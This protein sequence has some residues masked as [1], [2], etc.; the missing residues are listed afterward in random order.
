[1]AGIARVGRPAKDGATRKAEYDQRRRTLVRKV[2][3]HPELR[4]RLEA[5]PEEWLRYYC[6][7]LFNLP[8]ADS[9][10]QII[11]AVV[12][13]SDNAMNVVV[14]A[15]RGEGKTSILR[16]M[17]VFLI[18]TGRARFPVLGGWTG[19]AAKIGW[20]QWK[21]M[22]TSPRFVEDYPEFA[23]P[24]AESTNSTR[25]NSLVWDDTGKE[26]G[27]D[28]LAVELVIVLPDGRGALAAGSLNGDIKGTNIPLKSGEVIRPDMILLDDPQD[29]DRAG[30]PVFVD[31]VVDKIN[32]Q[33]MCLGGPDSGI[34]MMAAVTIKEPGDVG[35]TL[36]SDP[37]N[38]FIRISRILKWP[39]GFTDKN[40]ACR[41]LWDRWYD[42]F[43]DASTREESFR[44]YEANKAVMIKGMQVAWE[45]RRDRKRK[46]PDAFFSAIA[47]FYKVGE[48]AF[49]S[50]YQNRP[51]KGET[52]VY[53]LTPQII[54]SRTVSLKVNQQP[55][56]SVLRVLC[57]D[58]NPSYAL[59]STMKAFDT[60][61]RGHVMW[62]SL[63]SEDPLPIRNT[64]S[65][66]MRCALVSQALFK[67][68][69]VICALPNPPEHWGIDASGEYFDVVVDFVKNFKGCHA[70]AMCG[71]AGKNYNPNVKSR[72]GI[73]RNGVYECMER[74]KGKWLCFD[75]DIYKETAQ[76]AF[77]SEPGA[78]GSCTLFDGNHRELAIQT[79][80]ETLA[81]KAE[82]AG[83]MHYEWVTQPGKH[84]FL[85]TLSM[86]D[87][88]AG[89]NGIGAFGESAKQGRGRKKISSM[90]MKARYAHG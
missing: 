69:A 32:T 58:L 5:N 79:C 47:D 46:D 88:L 67:L 56:A 29:V 30:D 68:G 9:H 2:C 35:D 19:K 12:D 60:K 43:S 61:R 15:P 78:I 22:L 59:T 37:A 49:W 25:L 33:W 57:T 84:D 63:F 65:V 72:I 82:V 75:A 80:R 39:E 53:S 1:M 90:D 18:V 40:S 38:I 28:I 41:N 10:R 17:C 71:R 51:M 66:D 62:S 54:M 73:V 6:P 70:V 36:G 45:H 76:R 20:R 31:E 16:A 89:W 87:A 13:S 27:A 24:F 14:A 55:E 74:G 3:E 7:M 48:S 81:D 34:R 42:L 85:D 11:R 83:R 44:F 21:I 26:T 64:T 8:F 86:N 4:A 77:L 50:E 23:Q 52:K